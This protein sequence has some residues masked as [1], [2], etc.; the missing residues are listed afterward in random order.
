M[1]CPRPELL[2][3]LLLLLPPVAGAQAGGEIVLSADRAR[4]DQQAGTGVYEGNAEMNQGG[5]HLTA[6]RI[7]IQLENG[8]IS[9]V[10]AVGDPV[11][12][13]EGEA[14]DAH[15]RRLVYEINGKVIHL[16]E[17]A[18]VSH[19]GRTFE[20]AQ[21]RY[22][23]QTRQVEAS[24]DEKGRVRLVI[25]GEDGKNGSPEDQEGAPSP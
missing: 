21:V 15:A 17:D 12:L 13:T 24:G 2:L 16:F 18:F 22:D 1:K 20:G 14:L 9:R 19:E 10:E 8:E 3:S 25:P 6:E 7:F 23:L 5:R 4:I 11:R